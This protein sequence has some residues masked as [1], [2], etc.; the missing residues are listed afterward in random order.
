MTKKYKRKPTV[1]QCKALE[2][3]KRGRTLK[4]AMVLAGY[5]TSTSLKA[6]QNLT[7]SVGFQSLIQE[8]REDLKKAGVT[9]EVLAKIQAQGLKDLDA[10]VRLDYLKETKKDLGLVTD[11]S[12]NPNVKRRF[13]AEEFFEEALNK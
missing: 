10:K 12:D 11:S 1:K 2:N 6:K 13:V 3:I 9:K 5:K 4:D 8:Y 7:D